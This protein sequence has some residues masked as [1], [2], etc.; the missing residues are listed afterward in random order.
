MKTVCWLSAGVS[1][2]VALLLYKADV[3][4]YIDIDDQ[5]ADSFR[6]CRQVCAK[7]GTPLFIIRSPYGSVD[8]VCRS[9]RYVNG[10][11]GAKCTTVLKRAVRKTWES[12]NRGPLA[13]IWGMDWSEKQRV[14]RIADSMPEVD[15]IFPLVDRGMSKADAHAFLKL[16][17]IKRPVM[18]DLGYQNNNC[19]GCVK[20]GM[21]YWNKI[22]VDFPDIF[23]RRA[24]MERSIGRS[25]IK[26]LFLDT[27][28]PL[29]GKLQAPISEEC[30]IACE[31][32][33][34]KNE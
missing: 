9:H 30:G 5:H 8:R 18:Y 20:G 3:V 28:S 26:G 22:R 25:C 10:P 27:L 16:K 32:D 34:W 12:D 2:A 19:I 11:A 23:A 24:A 15:H 29:A 33:G 14:D 17:G 21:G 6:F 13:Y 1:S 7:A 31:V 4:I